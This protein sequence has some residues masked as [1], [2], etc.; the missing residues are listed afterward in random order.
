MSFVTRLGAIS[1]PLPTITARVMLRILV[2]GGL[3]GQ[4]NEGY[5]SEPC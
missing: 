3:A 1:V 4:G 2:P 5:G